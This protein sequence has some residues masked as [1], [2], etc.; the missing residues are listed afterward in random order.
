MGWRLTFWMLSYKRIKKEEKKT[1]N[2]T[3][4]WSQLDVKISNFLGFSLKEHTLCFHVLY[5]LSEEK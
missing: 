4:L 2:V 5:L 3:S 1:G